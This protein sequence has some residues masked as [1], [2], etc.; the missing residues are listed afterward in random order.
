MIKTNLILCLVVFALA[1]GTPSIYGQG[2]GGS[3][4]GTVSDATGG[5]L[6]GVEVTITNVDT[7]QS[8]F[9]VTGDEGRYNAVELSIGNYEVRAELVGFQT[10]VRQGVGLQV[11]Q[12]AVINLSLAVG[13]ISEE[14]I[15]TGEAPLINT[16]SATLSSPGGRYQSVPRR[17]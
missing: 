12:E 3:I 1:W 4:S 8:R 9:L 11:G 14:V 2:S 15:V 6:P 16:T 13:E 10:A 7:G 17:R 5:V